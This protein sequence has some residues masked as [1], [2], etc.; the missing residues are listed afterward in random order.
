MKRWDEADARISVTPGVRTG[1]AALCLAACAVSCTGGAPDP[2]ARQA[3]DPARAPDV[4]HVVRDKGAEIARRLGGGAACAGWR[5]ATEDEVWECAIAGLPRP[6]ELDVEPSGAFRELDLR[7]GPAEIAEAA[8]AAASAIADSCKDVGRTVAEI[9]IRSEP[10][11]GS[12][13][14]LARLW[15][16]EDVLIEVRCPDGSEFELDAFGAVVT[17]P[18]HD[19]GEGLD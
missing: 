5:W 16:R 17:I 11:V 7:L 14:R 8:P 18:G 15:G 10:L 19:V 1:L 6:G 2:A 12:D 4:P 13:T 9:S 3:D